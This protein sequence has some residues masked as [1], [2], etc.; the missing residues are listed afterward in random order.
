[1]VMFVSASDDFRSAERHLTAGSVMLRVYFYKTE[2]IS[3]LCTPF[4]CQFRLIC[5]TS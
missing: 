3:E 5:D 2:S 4:S 1:M